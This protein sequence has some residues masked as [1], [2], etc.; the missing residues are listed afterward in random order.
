MRTTSSSDSSS[1]P[2]TTGHPAGDRAHLRAEGIRIALGE[3]SVLSGVDLTV[4]SGDRLAIVGES[5]CGKTTLLHVLAGTL[6]PDA[7]TVHRTGTIALVEQAMVA[8]GGRT[9]G[10]LV[11]EA[12]APALSALSDLDAAAQALADGRDAANDYAAAL[13]AAT[14]LDAWDAERRVDTALSGLDA[15]TDRSR[16]LLSLS[17]GQRYRVRLAMALGAAPELLLLDEPT[18]H[19][20]AAALSFLAQ[21]LQELPGGVA[22][23]SHDRALLREVAETFLDLDPSRDGL[24]RHYA[25]GLDGWLEGRRRERAQWEQERAA[26]EAQHAQLVQAADEARSRMQGSWRP[27]KGTGK[28]T[29]ATRAAGVVQAFNRRVEELERHEITV[30]EPPLRLSW[31]D[32]GTQPGRPLLSARGLTVDGRLGEPVSLELTG[33]DRLLIA[34]PNG[35]GK[36]TLLAVLAGQLPPTTGTVSLHRSARVAL[37]SQEVPAWD[38]E[39]TGHRAYDEHLARAGLRGEAPELASL[40]LL[41]EASAGTP[42]GRMSQGQQR[43]LHLAMCLAQRPDLL[44][45]DEPT[46]HL[47]ATLVEELTEALETAQCAVVLATHDRQLLADAAHWP[48]RVL[49]DGSDVDAAGQRDAVRP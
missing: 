2:L 25:G 30:P 27:P 33:G 38:G 23:V 37:L 1:S 44:L 48:R 36:S 5:G 11:A 40:G 15:C 28:H 9:V 20:D 46:N 21:R 43:R 16:R 35:A 45:L 32:T 42:V 26:Q 14:A 39:H 12:I 31:P 8:D 19:L 49:G 6:Q 29:R 13:E 17:V 10:D 18:N 24:P 3:R 7:G 4:S 34:G 22:V 47:S 41:D